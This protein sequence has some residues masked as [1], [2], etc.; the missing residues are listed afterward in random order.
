MEKN[1]LREMV[2]WLRMQLSEAESVIKES[3]I[4]HNYGKASVFEGKRD[5]YLDCLRKLTTDMI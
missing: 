3:K 4:A 2:S 5:A 1:R